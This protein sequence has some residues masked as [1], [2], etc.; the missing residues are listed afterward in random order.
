MNKSDSIA[1]LSAALAK[2]QGELK[3][4]HFDSTNPHFKSKFASLGAVRES[5]I[6]TFTKHGLSLSQW[7]ISHNGSAGCRTLVT[8]QSGE[9]IEEEFLIPVDKH[10]AHGYAS[11]VTYS[12]RIAMQSV[13]GVVG[14]EDDDGNQ[15]VGDNLK[16]EKTSA[17]G[18]DFKRECFES[19][20]VKHQEHLQK[21]AADIT[22]MVTEDRTTDA[23]LFIEEQ[24]FDDVEKPALWHLLDSNIRSAIKS[25][26][27]KYHG[28]KKVT[29]NERKAQSS[30]AQ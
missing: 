24:R 4:P 18:A 10:N 26:S 17:S 30:Y 20:P 2:A 1:A 15:A 16:G 25:A 8:H 23:Y 11:A 14:D 12:K 3:N 7:P 13:A 21:L 6:P 9:W 19:L 22:A 29:R 5:V 28:V 27:D